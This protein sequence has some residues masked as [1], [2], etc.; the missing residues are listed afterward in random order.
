LDVARHGAAVLDTR[1]LR[2]RRQGGRTELQ[3]G[4]FR[5][6]QGQE[7]AR[8]LLDR[9]GIALELTTAR[10]PGPLVLAFLCLV[11]IKLQS[12]LRILI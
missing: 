6:R 1:R 5:R 10:R 9:V 2:H 8:R 11:R 7:T 3:L 4:Q 12:V